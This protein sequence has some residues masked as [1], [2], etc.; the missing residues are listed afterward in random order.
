MILHRFL[1][2]AALVWSQVHAQTQISP[3]STS[4]VKVSP[5]ENGAPA[6]VSAHRGGRYLPGYPENALETVQYTLRHVPAIIE[7]DVNMTADSVLILMHDATLDRTTDGS[8][9]VMEHS[10]QDIQALRLVD[11][12]GTLTDYRVPRLENV[13]DWGFNKAFWTLDVKRKVPFD[14]VIDAVRSVGAINSV[15]LITYNYEDAVQAYLLDPRIRLSVVI[16]NEEE[17]QRYIDG[18]IP[19]E[20]L[21]AF[22]GLTERDPAFYQKLKSLGMTVMIGTIGNLDQKAEARGGRIYRDLLAKGIDVIATDRPCA[23]FEA[24]R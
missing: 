19:T 21:M 10:W 11:D 7:V 14:R 13:L 3:C 6:I 2:V 16:R 17:L 12:F 8:G 24:I 9:Q 4:L 20:N 22:T 23:V 5:P 18:P 15:A 1:L